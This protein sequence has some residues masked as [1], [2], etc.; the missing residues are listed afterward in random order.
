MRTTE[1]SFT[2]C[3]ADTMLTDGAPEVRPAPRKVL[4]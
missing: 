2:D 1:T 4:G 3:G